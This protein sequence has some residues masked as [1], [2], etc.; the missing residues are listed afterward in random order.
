MVR[1]RNN[2]SREDA[3]PLFRVLEEKPP[4][5]RKNVPVRPTPEE[6]AT[7]HERKSRFGYKSLS[8][9]LIERGLLEGEMIAIVDRRKIDRLLYE[10]R[11][12]GISI[13]QIARR[14]NTGHRS[15]SQEALDRAA[16]QVS[17]IL[18]EIS[19]AIIK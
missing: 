15:I 9:Y 6:L 13:N 10:L 2:Q 11:K 4:K 3:E 14:L 1:K 5:R 16:T 7:L 8:K 18:E 17:Q 12:M 19:G